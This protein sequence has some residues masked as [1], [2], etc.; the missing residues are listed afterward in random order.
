MSGVPEL[1][2]SCTRPATSYTSGKQ[3]VVGW[4]ESYRPHL[5]LTCSKMPAGKLLRDCSTVWS[6]CEAFIKYLPE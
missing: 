5:H 4:L 2:L 3:L 6:M 1:K